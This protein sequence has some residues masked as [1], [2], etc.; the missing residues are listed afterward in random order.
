[1]VPGF[2]G[3][4]PCLDILD[5]AHGCGHVEGK[6]IEG[7]NPTKMVVIYVE[8]IN[9]QL[10]NKFQADF[11]TDNKIKVWNQCE[12]RL[13]ASCQRS[14]SLQWI[15]SG[16]G[17]GTVDGKNPEPPETYQSLEKMD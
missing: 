16:S 17:G 3:T 14:Y 11:N 15:C 9:N 5:C 2:L 12:M 13:Y 1:M 10:K 7:T 8:R 4:T 6:N